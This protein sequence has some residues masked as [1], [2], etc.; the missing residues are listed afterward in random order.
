MVINYPI[1]TK[2]PIEIMS[3]LFPNLSIIEP[4]I[5]LKKIFGNA[6]N[7]Y[8]ALKYIEKLS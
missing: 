1:I 2:D 4:L 5:G 6:E 3:I 7:V 8:K